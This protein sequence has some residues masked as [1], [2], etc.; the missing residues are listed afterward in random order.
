M[1]AEKKPPKRLGVKKQP[2]KPGAKPKP[3]KTRTRTRERARARPWTPNEKG[4]ERPKK[5]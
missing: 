1:A 4:S 5:R 3:N 2:V